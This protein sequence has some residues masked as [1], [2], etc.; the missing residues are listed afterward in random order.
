MKTTVVNIKK[1]DEFDVYIGR[2]S[3]WGNP[4]RI[5]RD[6]TRENV[7]KKYKSYILNREDLM[8]Q[9]HKLKGKTLGCFC[10]PFHCHGDVLADLADRTK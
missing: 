7:I 10:S 3:I 9:L 2:G 5:G 1:T 4:F 8:N 6:G